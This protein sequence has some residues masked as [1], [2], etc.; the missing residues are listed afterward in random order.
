MGSYIPN[1]PIY[2]SFIEEVKTFLEKEK[3]QII[4]AGN[5]CAFKQSIQS[6]KVDLMSLEELE[7]YAKEEAINVGQEY[8]NETFLK[9]T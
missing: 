3:Q 2:K 5:T 7:Q 9:K 4:E 1:A 8:Y 6:R